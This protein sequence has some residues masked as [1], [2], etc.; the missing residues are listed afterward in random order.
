MKRFIYL[1][2][3]SDPH[4]ESIQAIRRLGYNVGIF[5]DSNLTLKHPESYD[6]II[7]IDFSQLD[8][9]MAR[10]KTSEL[11]IDGLV[12]TYENYVIAKCKLAQYLGLPSSSVA[13]AEMA[14]DK[15]LMRQAFLR[16]DSTITPRFATISSKEELLAFADTTVYPLIIKPTNLVKSLLVLRC[17]NQEE[18]LENFAY[19]EATIDELYQKY[20]I[21]DREPQLIVEEFI[22]GKSCSV[23][24]FVDHE[25]VPHFCE[26][27]VSLTTAHEHGM[28]DTYLYSRQLPS[29]VGDALSQKIFTVSEKGVK[30][31]DMRSTPAHIE[32]MYDGEDVKII[33]IGARIGGYRP[34]MY[35]YSYG[36]NLID[37]EVKLAIKQLP[38]LSGSFQAYSS[39]FELFPETEGSFVKINTALATTDAFKYFH[40]RPKE[41]QLIGPA[42]NGH[43]ATAT[44]IIVNEDKATFDTLCHQVDR[45]RV[46]VA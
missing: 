24:A 10:L 36:M 38:N 21:Y 44:I 37:Q 40:I 27:I 26:G 25:G 23:A 19:A 20:N 7:P 14:T 17:D 13:S 3:K 41:G 12:C 35:E 29:E 1:V 4:S 2:G 45:M 6:T 15:H 34:R 9:E 18:L 8:D 28:A 42:K 39:V 32:L 46:E 16:E 30:A 33:E 43:K 22:T 11:A 5:Q 31:L